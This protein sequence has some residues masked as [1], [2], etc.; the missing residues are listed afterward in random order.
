MRFIDLKRQY[1]K[2]RNAIGRAIQRVL[3]HGQ[4]ILGPEVAELEERLAAY[5][6]TRHCIAVASGTDSL[7]VPLTAM[8]IGPGDEVIT[9]PFT[10]ISPAEVIRLR[11]AKPVFV[12]IKADDYTMDPELLEAAITERTRAII[13]VSLYGQMPRL[14]AIAAI[15]DRY[16]IPV[17]EDGAQS[18]GA[19]RNGTP[20]C[21]ATKVGSTSFFPSK[22]LGA[23]GDGGA[24]FTD[25]DELAYKMKAIRTHGSLQRD[26][27]EF[28][29]FNSRLDTLQAAILLAKF[30]RFEEELEAR[31]YVSARYSQ[32]LQD[33][34]VV[35]QISKGN[36]HIFALYTVRC[37][38]SR[39]EVVAE[40]TARDIPY[41]IY[42][43]Q[44]AHLQPAFADLGYRANSFPV[45]EQAM[46]EVLSL[47]M[48]PWLTEKEQD[49]VVEAVRAGMMAMVG[50]IA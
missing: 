29:G 46:S 16:G 9:V 23:Y 26:H 38:G 20:S 19:R 41:G 7:L 34:C 31:N 17:I 10:F 2:Q 48:H 50:E 14:E 28:I 36:T 27:H 12:D 37:Q 47:P 11:G 18:F 3:D 44:C 21:G 5:V 6:G 32:L 24:I 49:H 8:E 25:D 40:L 45:A 39:E 35:P 42:Y 33:C 1:A 43:S 22:P 30:S 13:P 4:F 15:A